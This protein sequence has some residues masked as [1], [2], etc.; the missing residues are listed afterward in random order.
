MKNNRAPEDEGIVAE[1]LKAYGEVINEI[2]AKI[3]NKI[4][5]EESI[6][7]SWTCADIIFFPKNGNKSD[8][9]TY[10]PMSILSHTYMYKIFMKIL[11]KRLQKP[12]WM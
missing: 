5:T 6:P 11:Q 3:Y 4:I 10:R 2:F 9:R 12:H 8:Q 1:H 7:E